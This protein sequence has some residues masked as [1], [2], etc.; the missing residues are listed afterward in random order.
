M[1]WQQMQSWKQRIRLILFA[2]LGAAIVATLAFL[3]FGSPLPLLQRLQNE[4]QSAASFSPV[5]F[6]LISGQMIGVEVPL[7]TVAQG[8]SL[9]LGIIALALCWLTWRGRI[10][11]RGGTDIFAAYLFTALRFRIWYSTWLFPWI[12]LD[13]ESRFRLYTGCWFLLLSQLSVVLYG[14]IRMAWLDGSLPVAL[15]LGIPFVFGI[16]LLIGFFASKFQFVRRSST[17]TDDTY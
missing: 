11:L 16:P 1:A 2:S 9:L 13:T 7:S 4:A 14:H 5:Q 8:A 15:L 17:L 10:P 6:V 3:P 12:V